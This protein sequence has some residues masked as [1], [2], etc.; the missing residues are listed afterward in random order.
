MWKRSREKALR[1]QLRLGRCL[2]NLETED[3]VPADVCGAAAPL[4]GV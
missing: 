4:A 1:R 2:M 3:A